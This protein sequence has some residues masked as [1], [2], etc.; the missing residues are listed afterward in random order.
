[1]PPPRRPSASRRARRPEHDWTRYAAPAA[2]LLAATIAILLIRSGLHGSEPAT[3]TRA[4]T[5]VAKPKPKPKPATTRKT[6]TKK[7]TTGAPRYYTVVAGD[8]FATIA[9]KSGTTVA[10]LERLNPGVKS[11]SLFIGQRIRV[12]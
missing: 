2:F 12:G 3:T 6:T 1:V 4:A 5:A 10:E 9:S 7:T 11:T 8:T